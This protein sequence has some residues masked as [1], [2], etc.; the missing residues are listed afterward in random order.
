MSPGLGARTGGVTLIVAQRQGPR[1]KDRDTYRV[2]DLLVPRPANA[3]GQGFKAGQVAD[4]VPELAGHSRSGVGRFPV[5][6]N[7]IHD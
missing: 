5:S 6:Q 4:T 3:Y 7:A 2:P 1:V